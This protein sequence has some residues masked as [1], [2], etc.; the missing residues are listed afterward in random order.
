MNRFLK[1]YI[2]TFFAHSELFILSLFCRQRG[3]FTGLQVSHR[4]FS[5]GVLSEMCRCTI[6]LH[7]QNEN[8]LV[9]CWCCRF[10]FQSICERRIFGRQTLSFLSSANSSLKNWKTQRQLYMNCYILA[11]TQKQEMFFHCF[12][13]KSLLLCFTRFQSR[14][15][16]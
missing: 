16:I 15:I 10:S 14:N 8:S 13:R 1:V 11:T 4:G 3:R 2:W 5:S 12:Q 9:C 7:L 6:V